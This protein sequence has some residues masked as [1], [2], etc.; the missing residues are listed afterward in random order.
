MQAWAM[1]VPTD[2]LVHWVQQLVRIPS[3]NPMQTGPKALA[4]GPIGERALALSVADSFA[5]LAGDVELQDIEGERPN[6]YGFFHGRTERL[7]VLDVH[8][9]TVTVEHMTD[10]PFDG[11]VQDGKIWGR[12]SVDT[13]ASLGVILALLESWR[14]NGLKPEPTLLV[15]GSVSEEQGGLIGA[16]GFRAWAE[17][18]GL[19]ID[20]LIVSE[21]TMGCPIYGHKGGVGFEV[22]VHGEAAHSAMPHLGRSAILAAARAILALEE[23]HQRLQSEPAPTEVGAGSINVGLINGGTGGN[24]VPDRCTFNLGRRVTPGE[25]PVAIAA[26]LRE[27]VAQAVA[28]CTVDMVQMNEGSSGFYQPP[29]SGLV[30]TLA[31]AAGTAATTAPYGTNAIKY[32][33]LASELVVFGPGSIERAHKATEWVGIDELEQCAR[34]FEAWLQPR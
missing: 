2:R 34:A 29:D 5:G 15:V 23:E 27:L 26:A 20:Q 3:V 16:V 31:A 14:T 4:A 32:P 7:V 33:G 12:G 19:S 11:R 1:T 28:P 18:R 24:V 21:P 30:Q 13:K 10:P 6:V 9:D 17:A 8:T 22:T 25:D